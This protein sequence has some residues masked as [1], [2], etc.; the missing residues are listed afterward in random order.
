MGSTFFVRGPGS[1]RNRFKNSGVDTVSIETTVS[2]PAS[3]FAYKKFKRAHEF[4]NSNDYLHL[5]KKFEIFKMLDVSKCFDSIYT[6]TMYWAVSDIETAKDNT[7]SSGF[8]NDFDRLMQSMNYN[9]TNGICIGPEVSRVFAEIIFSEIDKRVVIALKRK[10]IFLKSGYEFRR[11]VD[12]YYV[13][14]QD[15]A[16]AN[17]VSAVIQTCLGQFNLHLNEHKTQTF[18]RPFSTKTSQIISEANVA[19]TDFFGKFL[20]T[21]VEDREQLVAPKRIMRADALMRSL[22]GSIK[23]TCAAHDTGYETMSDYVVSASSR[24]ITELADSFASYGHERPNLHED[25]I[26]ATML[27][28]EV[29]YFFYTVNPTVRSSLFVARAAVTAAQLFRENFPDRLPHLSENIVRWTLDLA[30]SI[31]RNSRHN[32]LTAIPIEVLNILIPMREIAASEPLVDELI[33]K[34]CEA[35]ESF[36]YFEIISFLFLTG[37]RVIHRPLIAALFMRARKLVNGGFGPRVDSQSAHLSLD[38][39]ACPYLPLDKRGSWFNVLRSKCGLPQLPRADAQAAVLAL[40][41][42]PWFVRWDRLD[43]L[44]LLRKKELS[45]VY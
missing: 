27:L 23:K 1:E 10:G 11:Y 34:L 12:D 24:R 17:K 40:Q 13:F 8:P 4:F 16:T 26:A 38:I 33:A 19:I 44:S 21:W 29:V 36:E 41:A 30:R 5:E 42:H 7:F 37:G 3:Y 2:N 15:E 39:L 31:G 18:R 20:T 32:D 14:A 45:A 9:E 25:Y 35:Q 43:L 6:H 28:L 22:V